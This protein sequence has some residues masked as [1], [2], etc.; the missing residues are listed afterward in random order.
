MRA[1]RSR[2]CWGRRR[3]W[4][5]VA[6]VLAAGTALLL[7]HL[8]VRCRI[9][10][11]DPNQFPMEPC[12]PDVDQKHLVTVRSCPT[13]AAAPVLTGQTMVWRVGIW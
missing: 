2:G 6:L 3:L 8:W 10:C 11:L 13:L 9:F 12:P 4:M 5:R 7:W 1:L